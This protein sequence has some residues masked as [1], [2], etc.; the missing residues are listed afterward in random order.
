MKGHS[1]ATMSFGKGSV[2]SSASA[3]KLV[4]RSSTESEVIGVYDNI[5]QMIWTFN[6]ME[7]QGHQME[8]IVL[9]QDNMSAILLETNGR[10]S[11]SKRTRHMNIRYFHIKDLTEG[12]NKR[13][14]I[15]HCPTDRML[16]DFFTKPVQGNQ[17]RYLRTHIMNIE[18]GS[19]YY[20][21]KPHR[22]VLDDEV[23]EHDVTD[24]SATA[25]TNGDQD[26]DVAAPGVSEETT[27]VKEGT[28]FLQAADMSTVTSKTV[29]TVPMSSRD[30]HVEALCRK[31]GRADPAS[32]EWTEVV[33]RRRLPRVCS[34]RRG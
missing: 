7:A 29:G 16:G 4:A 28:A 9:Y 27:R 14:I 30:Q 22:S 31:G 19:K 1:G 18:P 24:G 23:A 12:P 21:S 15:K 13:I 10:A 33:R 34:N 2:Y 6:Y 3:Q 32:T 11:S 26:K 8:S 25:A 17:F 20:Y 5:P